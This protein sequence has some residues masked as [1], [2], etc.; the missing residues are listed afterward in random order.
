[1]KLLT[2]D[3]VAEQLNVS[4]RTIRA[5]CQSG[6]LRHVCVGVGRGTIRNKPTKGGGISSSSADTRSDGIR[7]VD[8]K[9]FAAMSRTSA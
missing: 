7:S 9:T 1:M 3:E 4:P 6:R 2:V 5:L 8:S